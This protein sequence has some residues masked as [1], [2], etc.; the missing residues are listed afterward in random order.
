MVSE[1]IREADAI[2][3]WGVGAERSERLGREPG[4][5]PF[6]LDPLDTPR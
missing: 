5:K 1:G 3:R 4:A 6:A 2:P